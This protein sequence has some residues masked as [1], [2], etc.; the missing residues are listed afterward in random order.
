MG[1]KYFPG[2]HVTNYYPTKTGHWIYYTEAGWIE[3]EEWR[4]FDGIVITQE[5]NEKG[6]VTISYQ[7]QERIFEGTVFPENLK[8]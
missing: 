5:Y 4:D 3:K 1:T 8:K 2:H 6:D 7:T